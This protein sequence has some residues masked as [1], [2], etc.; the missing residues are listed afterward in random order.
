M[1]EV[2]GLFAVH[3]RLP[4]SYIELLSMGWLVG[5]LFP[6]VAAAVGAGG[7]RQAQE[8]TALPQVISK[9]AVVGELLFRQG[10]GL[11]QV[12]SGHRPL[13]LVPRLVRLGT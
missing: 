3:Q 2:T 9:I 8:H 4:P 11:L 7:F 5:G 1:E 12:L 13:T 6:L 10:L